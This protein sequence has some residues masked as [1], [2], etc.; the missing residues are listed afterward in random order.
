MV[1]ALD[2]SHFEVSQSQVKNVVMDAGTCIKVGAMRNACL[3]SSTC[4]GVEERFMLADT[5]RVDN[6]GF[7]HSSEDDHSADV[8]P[9]I[10]TNFTSDRCTV[11]G[12]RTHTSCSTAIGVD[13][14]VAPCANLAAAT[15]IDLT[16]VTNAKVG[17]VTWIGLAAA[18]RVD[19]EAVKYIEL[20]NLEYQ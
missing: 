15:S 1:I 20:G 5:L 17:S 4:A 9:T 6:I 12:M 18:V 14:T 19:T 10:S 13:C 2:T 16:L 7:R 8:A 3:S 11:S